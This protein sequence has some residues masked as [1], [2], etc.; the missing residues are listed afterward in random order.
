MK[1]EEQKWLDFFCGLNTLMVTNEKEF[2]QFRDFLDDIALGKLLNK[3]RSFSDWQQLSVI[4]GKD[5]NCIIF[6]YQPTKGMTFGYTIAS[7]KEW[8]EKEPMTVK[9]L[10]SFYKSSKLV[11]KVSNLEIEEEIEK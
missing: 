10:V 5:P 2:N 6:E 4:N 8:Y 3:Y 1:D 7:S 11:E 9:D